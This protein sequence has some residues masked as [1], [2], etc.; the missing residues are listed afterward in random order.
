MTWKLQIQGAFMTQIILDTVKSEVVDKLKKLAQKHDRSLEA[1]ITAILENATENI[2]ISTPPNRGW[3]EGFF[4]EV[5]GSWAGE[6][7][8]REPQPEYQERDFLF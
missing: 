3:S 5:I 8:V 4:E 1:E 6:P 7:L 2:P